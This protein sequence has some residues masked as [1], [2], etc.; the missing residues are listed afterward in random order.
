MSDALRSFP[1]CG[2]RLWSWF[3]T[4][5]A[6]ERLSGKSLTDIE[7]F[8]LMC[9][10]VLCSYAATPPFDPEDESE[11]GYLRSIAER[12]GWKCSRPAAVR[13]EP[14]ERRAARGTE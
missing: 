10:E 6:L 11:G 9:A 5:E 4:R 2:E 8:D 3:W 1:R 13:S 12:D 7:V 14:A